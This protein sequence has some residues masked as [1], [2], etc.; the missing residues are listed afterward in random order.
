MDSS[1]PPSVAQLAGRFREQEAAA[2]EVSQ[3]VL[4]PLF[5]RG[6]GWRKEMSGSG[7]EEREGEAW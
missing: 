1:A 7:P 2:K 5:G 3:A 4:Q 6:G